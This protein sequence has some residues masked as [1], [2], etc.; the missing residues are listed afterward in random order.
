MITSFHS[1]GAWKCQGLPVIYYSQLSHAMHGQLPQQV[2][3]DTIYRFPAIITIHDCEYWY[4]HSDQDKV[5]GS[6]IQ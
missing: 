2:S 6:Y 4:S 3:M 5:I 1:E